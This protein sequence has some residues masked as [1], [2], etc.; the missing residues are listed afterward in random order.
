MRLQRLLCGLG[1]SRGAA[2]A[3]RSA[4][5]RSEVDIASK[6]PPETTEEMAGAIAAGRTVMWCDWPVLDGTACADEYLHVHGWAYCTAGVEEIAVVAHGRRFEPRTDLPRPDV[7]RALPGR[8]GEAVGF[9]LVLDTRRWA[10]GSHELTIR[11]VGRG[12]G[13][14]AQRGDVQVGPDLPYRAWLR[15]SGRG[16]ASKSG[17]TPAPAEGAAPL[18]VHVIEA[19]GT[20]RTRARAKER[21]RAPGALEASLARQTHS[22]WHRAAGPLAEVLQAVAGGGE[23]AVLVEDRGALAPH[24]LAC[25]AAAMG[26][27][28]APDLVYA[29]EDAVMADGERGDAF[30]KPGW[31]P[32]LLLATDYVGPLVAIGPRAAAAA[33]AAQARAPATIY[34]LLLRILDASLSVERI[35]ETLFTSEAPR[36]PADDPR[37]RG[38]IGRLAARRG[39]RAQVV[40]LERPGAR[41]VR[42]ELDREPL[43]SIVIP[44]ASE[45]LLARCLPSL[46]ERTTYPSF[47]VIVVDSSAEGLA[48]VGRL[49]EGVVHRVV[50]YRGRFSFST[51]V[52]I[53][54]GA[55]SGDHLLLL[56]DDT[57]VRTPD[58]IERM[59]EHL[60]TP[61]VGVVGCKLLYPRG[62]VQHAGVVIAR[63]AAGVGHVNMGFPADAPGYRGMLQMT[64]NWSAVTGA[65]MMVSADLFEGLGGFDESFDS[66]FSDVD[67][68]LR[69]IE[70]GR[71][72]V[73]TPRAVLTH[74]ERSSLPTEAN[75]RDVERFRERWSSRYSGGDPFYHPAFLPLS[76]ELP[77]DGSPG[78]G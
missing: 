46:R 77:H 16:E 31:S 48:S 43:V 69:A 27:R 36:T 5:L 28:P 76:Y 13:A 51:A 38:A 55:A 22:S 6:A 75:R 17:L 68:C 25:L 60:L 71:R 50:P 56:N 10:P 62:E 34:E 24:A 8:R 63:S 42:W 78:R 67:L 52:N 41:D 3:K 1:S 74:H 57:E 33:I 61:G 29:D 66:E 40:A 30:L 32:E 49:L 39:R 15:R 64:R 19:A 12:G 9:F 45:S 21:K 70:R 72:V 58:W 37:T 44:S 53:G 7:N 26:R 11:A 20:P 35:P 54:A 23:P 4:S 14:V 2:R 47:E 18:A 65:C 73:W 59:L